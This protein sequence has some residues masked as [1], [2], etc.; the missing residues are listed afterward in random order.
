MCIVPDIAD[1]LDFTH[2]QPVAV[3]VLAAGFL[4]LAS[5]Q[6][7]HKRQSTLFFEDKMLDSTQKDEEVCKVHRLLP[8]RIYELINV[9][10]REHLS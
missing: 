5:R 2:T 7:Q 9:A 10:D 3:G 8:S 6:Q 1:L 4:I